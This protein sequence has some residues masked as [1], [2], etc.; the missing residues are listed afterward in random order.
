MT[1]RYKYTDNR[2]LPQPDEL[3]EGLLSRVGK[4]EDEIVDFLG[5]A[6]IERNGFVYHFLEMYALMT[7]HYRD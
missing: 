7:E 5:E 6:K 2:G 1:L 3:I 4:T